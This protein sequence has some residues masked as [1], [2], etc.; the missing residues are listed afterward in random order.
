IAAGHGR[1]DAD[2]A[3]PRAL[4]RGLRP[5]LQERFVA[6]RDLSARLLK[7]SLQT[8]QR[9]GEV[10]F[11]RSAEAVG[12]GPL[13]PGA[14]DLAA[15]R[16]EQAG[17][18]LALA[19]EALAERLQLSHL[20]ANGRHDPSSQSWFP[21]LLSR[22]RHRNRNSLEYET[23]VKGGSPRRRVGEGGSVGTG[24]DQAA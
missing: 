10:A 5:C 8:A 15:D 7:C 6:A 16:R 9:G 3:H 11:P 21:A 14:V 1:D 22:R 2:P 13:P 23:C 24:Y 12:R 19:R 18:V 20:G 17:N 4:G